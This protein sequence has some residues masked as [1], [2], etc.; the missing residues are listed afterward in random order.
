MKG[1]GPNGDTGG[2]GVGAGLLMDKDSLLAFS[3]VTKSIAR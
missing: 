1:S 2:T 3:D